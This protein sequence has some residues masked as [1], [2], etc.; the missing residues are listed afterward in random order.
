MKP[1]CYYIVSEQKENTHNIIDGMDRLGF[2]PI[3]SCIGGGL[4]GDRNIII[5]NPVV[6]FETRNRSNFKYFVDMLKL[7]SKYPVTIYHCIYHSKYTISYR[8]QQEDII[9][10]VI[11]V[12][13]MYHVR[14]R[15][16]IDTDGLKIVQDAI[17][18]EYDIK[19][20]FIPGLN[21]VAYDNT[22]CQFSEFVQFVY[23]L[24]V[25]LF[26]IYFCDYKG[27]RSIDD[28]FEGIID[29]HVKYI[30]Y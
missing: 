19:S 2:K 1:M 18:T 30:D 27:C 5:Y 16:S 12:N 25:D 11:T 22:I 9:E 3:H 15:E 13:K 10:K 17:E 20:V 28:E 29:D 6:N 21:T 23:N 8:P 14:M 26:G 4:F 24:D 7:V